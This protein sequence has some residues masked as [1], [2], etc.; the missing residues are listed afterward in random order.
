MLSS[1]G[2][3]EGT[4]SDL[5]RI[6]EELRN[7][8]AKKKKKKKINHVEKKRPKINVYDPTFF[9]FEETGPSYDGLRVIYG[10]VLE[11]TAA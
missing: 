4:E 2:S 3:L 11:I 5:R 1:R 9:R 7:F 10:P 6:Y 8:H